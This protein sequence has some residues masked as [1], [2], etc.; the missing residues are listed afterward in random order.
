MS[1]LGDMFG[2]LRKEQEDRKNMLMRRQSKAFKDALDF[3]DNIERLKP[4]PQQ[5]FLIKLLYRIPLDRRNKVIPVFDQF[6]E[7]IAHL[8]TEW[9]FFEYLRD[10]KWINLESPEQHLESYFTEF[11]G[12]MGRRSGKS[13]ITGGLAAYSAAELLDIPNPQAFFGISPADEINLKSIAPTKKQGKL[14]FQFAKNFLMGHKFFQDFKPNF[15]KEKCSF[16]TKRELLDLQ[17]GRSI[18][19]PDGSISL[20]FD[21]CNASKLRG[22]GHYMLIMDESAHFIVDNEESD[23]SDR[24]IYDSVKPSMGT[25]KAEI[26]HITRVF[27]LMAIISSPLSKGG[28][29]YDKYRESFVAQD[30]IL[31]VQAPT[32]VWNPRNQD[33]AFLKRA[34]HQ[35][36]DV[37]MVEY[38]AQFKEG[39][40]DWFS[41][42][43]YDSCL[44]ND[45][46]V[47]HRGVWYFMG[48]DFGQKQDA[49]VITISHIKQDGTVV[50]DEVR[51]WSPAE[52]GVDVP[53]EWVLDTV[54]TLRAKYGT[55]KKGM[56]DQYNSWGFEKIFR[57]ANINYI[58]FE[59]ITSAKKD[60]MFSITKNLA[61]MNQLKLP[62]IPQLRKEMQLFREIRKE[63]R[64]YYRKSD[65]G[66]DD[67][68][69]SLVRSVYCA[70]TFAKATKQG[71]ERME[72]EIHQSMEIHR[73]IDERLKLANIRR[74]KRTLGHRPGRMMGF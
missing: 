57:D 14:A 3:F 19:L 10:N 20:L 21:A 68:I 18:P 65:S 25:Y 15:L 46:G 31:M 9:E 7:K 36:P 53:I 4:T 26:D 55:I 49:T 16:K 28:L 64:V 44:I 6:A 30:E 5:R 1:N 66:S 13:F 58:D 47:P 33:P 51:Y 67:F 70:L 74:V 29:L 23:V 43:Q 63:G 48:I 24:V 50:I 69:D 2:Q 34:Y 42:G 27:S 60:E 38:G 56:S 37:Y 32:W 61:Q 41:D 59:H 17:E 11:I 8:F 73:K 39:V 22:P 52:S 72:G 45:V 35:N 54:S 62:E 71:R 12:I 40:F